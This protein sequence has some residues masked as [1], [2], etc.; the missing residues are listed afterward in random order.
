MPFA[1]WPLKGGREMGINL[2]LVEFFEYI[3]D[4]SPITKG[5]RTTLKFTMEAGRQFEVAGTIAVR[6]YAAIEANLIKTPP[7]PTESTEPKAE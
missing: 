1:V 6:L 5:E 4:D 2:D 7:E 3:A